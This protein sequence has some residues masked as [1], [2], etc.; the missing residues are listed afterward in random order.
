MS[1]LYKYHFFTKVLLIFSFILIQNTATANNTKLSLNVVDSPLQK[2]LLKIESQTTFNFFYKN[3]SLNLNRLV[4]I[5]V[6]NESID[7]VLSKIFDK[8]QTI[9]KIVK[10]QIIIKKKPQPKVFKISGRTVDVKTGEAIP[11]CSV[12]LDNLNQGTSSNELGEFEL[13]VEKLPVRIIISHLSYEKQ[14]IIVR[15]NKSKITVK[16]VPLANILDEVNIKANKDKRNLYAIN[17]AK[18]AFKKINLLAK[19]RKKYGKA[20]YRQKTKS[21]NTYTEFSEIIFDVR[22]DLNGINNWKIL[23]GRY[24][25]KE[26]SINNKNFTRFS[27][28]LKAFQPDTDDIIFPL[29]KKLEDFYDVSV[30][31]FY[32]EK[33]YRIAVLTFKPQKYVKTPIFSGEAYINTKTNDVLKITGH[34]A[35][36]DFKF[37]KFTDKN[38]HKENY[39]LSFDVVFKKGNLSETLIDY[40][41]VNQS[42][43]YFKDFT[44]Q[45]KI[46]TTSNLSFFE[47][48]KPTTRKKLG[49]QFKRNDSDWQKL[50]KIGYDKEFWE[51]NPIVK[52]TPVEKEVIA[53]FE[54]NNAFESIFINSKNQISSLPSKL[55][56]D[57]FIKNF[58]LLTRKYNSY[59][60]REKVYLHTDKNSLIAGENLK[61]SAFV[62][63]GAFLNYS[64][65]S[66][67]LH[68]E[69][70]DKSQT[71]ISSQVIHLKNGRTSGEIKL[72]K[73]LP[74][75]VYQLRA[76]S[77]WMRNFNPEFIFKKDIEVLS[78]YITLEKE[79]K[80]VAKI[81]LQF[82]PEGGNAVVDLTG[83]IAFKAIN[84]NGIGVKVTG[85]VVNSKGDFV[86]PIKSNDDGIGAFNLKPKSGETYFAELND[87]TR[88][89]ITKINPIG[90]NMMVDNLNPKTI[91]VKV[92]SSQILKG[93]YFYF[94]GQMQNA[95]Y[96]HGRYLFNN[97]SIVTIE[98]P[99]TK[100]PSGILT[101]T[102]FDKEMKPWSERV[103]FVNNQTDLIIK[104]DYN[105]NK[106]NKKGKVPVN[107]NVT[108]VNGK[109]VETSISVAITDNNKTQ[110]GKFDSNILSYFLLESD[111]KGHISNPYKYFK[112]QERATIYNLDLV[113]L[114]HGWRRFDWQKIKNNQFDTIKRH[115]FVSGFS[116][117]GVAKKTNNSLFTNSTIKM[118]AKSNSGISIHSTK[119]NNSGFF[120]VHD[121]YHTDSTQVT[122]NGYNNNRVPIDINITLDK[123]LKSKF[124]LNIF[125][126]KYKDQANKTVLTEK[127]ITD[128]TN[129]NFKDRTL[130]DEV[131]IIGKV[132]RKKASPTIYGVEPDATVFLKENDQN[133]VQVLNRT[134]GV[135]VVGAGRTAKVS[136]R[137]FGSPLWVLDGVPLEPHSPH[138]LIATTNLNSNPDTASPTMKG[139]GPVPDVIA[140]LDT[141]IIE[142]IEILKGGKAAIYGARGNN[143]VILIYTKTGGFNKKRVLSP[144]FLVKGLT[145]A[146]EYY[147]PKYSVNKKTKSSILYWNPNIK[148]DKNGNATFSF[149][150]YNNTNQ[151]QIA[152]ETLS[153]FGIPGVY[154]KTFPN[155]Q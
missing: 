98:I 147:Q 148:T 80:K 119:T 109:P 133:F 54:Q 107:I 125:K 135:R 24:A 53:S 27:Q 84:Q 65:I 2:V 46:S 57:P 37:I 144:E 150:N 88:Y 92:Q 122:F 108:D 11:F 73:K 42:F 118:V 38:A 30:S 124:N 1:K 17:L 111:L 9:Y 45:T 23:E 132:K 115:Q 72:P 61:F 6:E 52:R 40:I 63:L 153:N 79:T 127:E 44:F 58:D 105:S 101:L 102:L 145:T 85:E 49:G 152:I 89:P 86:A 60:P 70:V 43:D 66:N 90:Y 140:N 67:I 155:K 16:L 121:I 120:T 41:N 128:L 10:N 76:Y 136:I 12:F 35:K 149:T 113:M 81:D 13:K 47:Y 59:N 25:L 62:T 91:K 99:K 22:Y 123:Q 20:F 71:I 29:H 75:G 78:D 146:K 139:A 134:S 4:T 154:L 129:L 143:G 77:N 142:R 32:I 50:N 48:Y 21:N 34:I 104:T 8:T 18:N 51:N 116:I 31:K 74:D 3:N 7:I 39:N 83:K 94:I 96:F 64:Q 97:K 106:L 68:V 110:K 100:V 26:A 33:N 151:L 95:K 114:T 87:K 141:Q 56:E 138:P 131:E 82:F 14:T 93:G 5:K 103:V 69:L 130:L 126:K 15:N 117:S 19:S 36:D 28:L 112:D 55:R 137:G